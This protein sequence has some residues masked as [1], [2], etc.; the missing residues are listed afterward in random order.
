VHL[1]SL[2]NVLWASGTALK[3]LLCAAVFYRRVHRRMPFFTAYA[4]LLVGEVIVV[5]MIYRIY[6]YTSRTAWYSYWAAS[7]IVLL[8]RGFVIAELCRI[9]FKHYPGLWSLARRTLV[10]TAGALLTCATISAAL[11]GYWIVGLVQ[12]S[13]R[14]LE[15]TGSII[16]ILALTFSIRYKAWMGPL[17]HGVLVGLAMYSILETLNRT[18]M[19]FVPSYLTAWD[20][21]RVAC[22]DLALI[23][24]IYAL[25]KPLPPPFSA[26]S[27][28]SE[29][30]A[31]ELLL[32]LLNGMR[33]LT[34]ELK[35]IG[36][37]IRK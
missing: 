29:Q 15:L 9:T 36:R 21:L 28:I 24:W 20:S 1:N 7:G 17:E 37:S 30:V 25:R 19:S 11:N 34:N 23:I 18:M 2:E 8:A 6:G 12:T 31:S 22:F 13:Q 32:R 27:L 3:V 26:T 4:L 14:G 10:L 35:E 5:W 16:L 33:E